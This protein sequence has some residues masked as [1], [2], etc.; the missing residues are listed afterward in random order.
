MT[1]IP[2]GPQ[3]PPTAGRSRHLV[4]PELLPVLDLLI[5]TS[6]PGGV[7]ADNLAATREQREAMVAATPVPEGSTTRVE[8]VSAPA[9]VEGDPEVSALVYHPA[10]PSGA[11][12]LHVHGGGYVMGSAQMA[13]LTNRAIAEQVGMLVVSV[14]YRLA[15]EHPHPAPVEDCYAGLVWLAENA[16][17]L[18]VDPA[19]IGVKGES[20][21]GG[22]A[23]ALALLARDRGGPGLAFQHLVYPMLDDRTPGGDDAQPYA[24]EYVWTTVNNRF[25][26]ESLL[27][28]QVGAPDTS[29]YAVPARA[30]DLAGL[31]PTYLA[32]GSIDLFVEEDLD[33]ARRLLR[34]G[35]PTEV[36]VYPGAF[37][38]FQAAEHAEVTAR[39]HR[40]SMDALRR[41]GLDDSSERRPVAG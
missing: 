15:P 39:F 36:H 4:D 22:L 5:E 23:A 38:A 24:G 29:P 31:P 27:G 34:A 37:H 14:D 20:A 40:D 10:E 30:A 32:T 9:Y 7:S 21:G 17:E 12:L 41:A 8:R 18:G 33:Y 28:G 19:R 2:P 6:P 11:A 26:W 13:D 16:E 35:V 3:G 25:G 1:T